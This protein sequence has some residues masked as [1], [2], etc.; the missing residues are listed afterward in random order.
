M[1]KIIQMVADGGGELGVHVYPLL[2]NIYYWACR[3][4]NVI[5]VTFLNFTLYALYICF[6]EYHCD[7]TTF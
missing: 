3:V 1:K 6:K 7:N 4:L 2:S 5:F